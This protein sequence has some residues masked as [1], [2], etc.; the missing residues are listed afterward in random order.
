MG[1][2]DP[3]VDA[4]I[5]KSADFARPILEYIREVVHAAV[6]DVEET[7][8]WSFPHFDH[9]GIMCSMAAFKEHGVFGFWKAPLVLGDLGKRDAMGHFGRLTTVKDLPPKKEFITL[10]RKA[11]RLNEQGVKLS[12]PRRERKNVETPDDL[13]AALKKDKKAQSAFEK[14]P[15][16]HRRDY[17]EWI[18]E[19]KTEGTRQR[20]LDQAVEWMSEGKSRNWKYMRKS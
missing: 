10:V 13:A 2:R 9:N 19:A 17:I 18:T 3:R 7:M 20:R 6:P 15:P 11:A 8:K 12:R 16:S 1:K 4:Y 14:F 5:K